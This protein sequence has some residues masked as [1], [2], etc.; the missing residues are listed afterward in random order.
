M[1]AQLLNYKCP[2]CG[3]PTDVDATAAGQTITCP[4]PLCQKPFK[5]EVPAAEP[6]PQL[7]IS[8]GLAHEVAQEQPASAVPSSSEAETELVSVYPLMFRR[9]PFR[10]LVYALASLVGLG[11]LLA[12]LVKGTLWV[13]LL[14]LILVSFGVY[15]LGH[16]WLRMLGTSVT[17]TTKRTL[18]HT[19]VFNRQITEVPHAEV[20]DL[21]VHQSLLNRLLGV[22][23]IAIVQ[24]AKDKKGIL[25]MGLP[26]PEEIAQHIRTRRQ[27]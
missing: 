24:Q 13:G 17:V 25:L 22:G 5:I 6:M 19:G 1:Q 16:W 7:I 14:G 8:P 26:Q 23:D 9:Y 2:H 4:N 18:L 27:V 12:G 15:K 11:L 20:A 3:Q 10:S 21:E